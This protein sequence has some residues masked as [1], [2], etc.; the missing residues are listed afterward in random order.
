M[1]LML[2]RGPDRLQCRTTEDRNEVL[3]AAFE[4]TIRAEDDE[5]TSAASYVAKR[6]EKTS[7]YSSSSAENELRS[8]SHFSSC[9]LL[10]R[11]AKSY[12]DE[13]RTSSVVTCA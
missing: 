6:S 11:E 1:R 10:A 9:A 5:H 2:D 12:H 7:A 4:L 3:C 8:S 13:Q